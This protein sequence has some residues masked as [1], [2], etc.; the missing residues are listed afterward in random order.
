MHPRNLLLVLCLLPLAAAADFPDI[1][2]GCLDCHRPTRVRLQIPIIE[3]QSRGYLLNQLRRFQERHRDSFPMSALVAGMS[4]PDL[5]ALA[6]ELSSRSWP[7]LRIR[8]E[9]AA[10]ERGRVRIGQLACE[11]CHGPAFL[12]EGDLPRIAGQH[13]GYLRRQLD[14]FGERH[15][16]HPPSGTGAPLTRLSARDRADIAAFL[17]AVADPGE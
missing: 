9:D 2:E 1:D 4:E 12:G 15:R 17:H 14:A 6:D 7:D 10:V 5:A 16:H 13:P 11:A 8:V 3:G